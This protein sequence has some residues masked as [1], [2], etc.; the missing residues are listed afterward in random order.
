MVTRMHGDLEK[1]VKA[2][3][4]IRGFVSGDRRKV[5]LACTE[6]AKAIIADGLAAQKAFY[7]RI[8]AGITEED[9]A[10]YKRINKLVM[11]N[12]MEMLSK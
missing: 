5:S 3:L 7:E 1:L 9:W 12:T 11:E 8:T 6:K 10:A 2:G 4:L